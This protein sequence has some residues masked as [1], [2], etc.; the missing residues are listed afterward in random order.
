MYETGSGFIVHFSLLSLKHSRVCREGFDIL[1]I[2]AFEEGALTRKL[3][4]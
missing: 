3:F 1:S 4:G 2:E